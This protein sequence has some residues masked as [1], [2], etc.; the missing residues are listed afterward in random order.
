MKRIAKTLACGLSFVSVLSL[1]TAGWAYWT[2]TGSGT[3]SSSVAT[4][5]AP[6]G[7]TV[8][9]TSNGSVAISWTASSTA[10]P[11]VTPTGYYVQRFGGTPSPAAACSTAPT[12]LTAAL[13][14]NDTGVADGTY[15]Y[16]V[17]AVF[18]S[19]SA[20]SPPTSSVVVTN[21]AL[22]SVSPASRGQG[23][24]SQTITLNGA[25]FTSG[26][27][28]SFSGTGVTVNTVSV[29][30]ASQLSADI[31]VA[32]AATTG[33]RDM[34]VTK[35]DGKTATLAGAFTVNAAPTL[36]A[37]SPSSRGRGATNQNIVV[38]G[39][40][41]VSGASVSF[42]GS[43]ITVNSTTFNSPTQLTLNLTVAS[44]AL[45]GPSNVVITNGD[46]GAGLLANGFTVNAG[47]TITSPS[48]ASTAK[49][50]KGTTTTVT[51]TGT[52]FVNGVTATITGEFTGGSV[53]WISSTQIAVTVSAPQG[54]KLK[55]S[56]TV[57]NSDG[58]TFTATDSLESTNN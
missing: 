36:T 56:I 8:P 58:G 38:T 14:C 53:N 48:A 19:W 5:A 37:L 21:L 31:S 1:A 44:T 7:V 16:R 39:T 3:G 23:A 10:S 40:G 35:P 43:G 28:V 26:T 51:V 9:A 13:T 25:G 2:T 29:V 27:T 41:F 6:T 54:N 46:G 55:G 57:T 24:T 20:S 11:N 12:A 22:T 17:T 33:P 47:P 45:I 34:T 15:T 50:N 52:G 42:S 4:L 18:R 32:D 30:N 49:V